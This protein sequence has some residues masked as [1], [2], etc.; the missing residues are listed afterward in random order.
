MELCLPQSHSTSIINVGTESK[1]LC[2]CVAAA[3][4]SGRFL[5]GHLYKS[6]VWS[7]NPYLASTRCCPLIQLRVG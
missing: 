6:L 2:I 4:L 1:V 5:S 7:I 3:I